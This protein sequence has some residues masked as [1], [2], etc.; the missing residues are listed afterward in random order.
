MSIIKVTS[1]KRK[2]TFTIRRY[3]NYGKCYAKYRTQSYPA[4]NFLLME[5][6]TETDWAWY[7]RHSGEYYVVR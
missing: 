3:D 5:E 7:L 2:R 1:N 4:R 6:Y